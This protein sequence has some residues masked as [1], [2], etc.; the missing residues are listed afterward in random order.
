[1]SAKLSRMS[2]LEYQLK[3][4]QFEKPPDRMKVHADES[5]QKPRGERIKT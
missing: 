5:N 4:D 1:M 2:K 3:N